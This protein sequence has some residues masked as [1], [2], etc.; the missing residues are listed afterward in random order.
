MDSNEVIMRHFPAEE[1]WEQ[2]YKKMILLGRN[3][4]SFSDEYKIDEFLIH[5]CQSQLWFKGSLNN[6]GDI[7]FTGDSE[8]LIGKGLLALIIEYCSHKKP[9]D[10]LTLDFKF[11]ETL[12][13]SQYLTA[14]RT[15]GLQSLI[16]QVRSYAKAFYI[17][18]QN[19]NNK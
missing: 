16:D 13:L 1:S 18:S 5:G 17:M 10:V 9:K 15:N 3:L 8:S 7:I 2:K 19:Q 6:D 11:I 12:N 14:K 4:P